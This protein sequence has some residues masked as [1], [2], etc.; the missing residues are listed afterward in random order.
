[1]AAGTVM[2]ARTHDHASFAD[3][4]AIINERGDMRGTQL[5]VQRPAQ[6]H[7]VRPGD[8]PPNGQRTLTYDS[9][10]AFLVGELERLDQTLHMPLAAVTWSR[11]IDLRGDVS[12]ADDVSSSRSRTSAAPA[13]W[14]RATASAT[15][16]PGS[17][18]C[19]TRSAA[20][21]STSASCRSR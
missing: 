17:A 21:R 13:T 6:L 7:D 16:R 15:A 12:M 14:A 4:R 3:P 18:R 5:A 20:C 2:R 1:V 10:G 19:P 8:L 9:T 11:D